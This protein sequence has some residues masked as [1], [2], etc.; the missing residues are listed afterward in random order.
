MGRLVAGAAP[1]CLPLLFAIAA[2]ISNLELD[3]SEQATTIPLQDATFGDVQ[4]GTTSATKTFTIRPATGAQNNQVQSVTENCPDFAVTATNLPATVS[5]VCSGGSNCPVFVTTTY[6]FT[7]VFTPTVAMQVSCVVTV[8]IDGTASTFT[9]SGRG[10]EPTVRIDVS[11]S[12]TLQLGEV[13]VGDTSSAATI[14][15]KNFGSGPQPMTVSA[16]SLDAASQAQGLAITSGTTTSHVVAPNGGNDLYK[17]TCHPTAPGPIAGTLTIASDDPAKPTSTVAITCAGITSNLVFLPSSP[18]L[19][20]GGQA[21]GGT[22]VGEPIDLTITLKNTGTAAMTIHDLTLTGAELSFVTRPAAESSLAINATT[23]VVVRYAATTAVDQGTLGTVVVSHD[24]G[25]TRTINVL[26]ASLAT[27]MSINPAGLVDLGPVCV[28]NTAEKAF[29]VLKNNPGTFLITAI[30]QPAPP[31]QLTGTLPTAGPLAIDNNAITFSASVTPTTPTALSAMFTVTTDIPNAPSQVVNLTALGLAAGVSA[32]PATV[33]LGTVS[34]GTTSTA[35]TITLTNCDPTPLTLQTVE[36]TGANQDDFA[37][38]TAPT[39]LA[40]ESGKAATY[41]VVT[42]P[43][44]GGPLTATLRIQHDRG[45]VEVPL[46]G[47]GTG[48]G[49]DPTPED[50]TYYSCSTGGARGGWPVALMALLVIRRRR[51]SHTQQP[52]GST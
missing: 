40:V 24:N 17:V 50:S 39:N 9:L 52:R 16:V 3:S 29:F 7:A 23:D 43:N 18:A 5:N 2:C 30:D 42:A 41:T 44:N 25:Q 4:V 10:T 31:F 11:P 35:Q 6:D 21:Q 45:I 46:F 47:A 32:T 19:L 13:R 48:R 28:M 33:D 14:L 26:G 51:R 15:V 22:R 36:I 12:T 38:V 37:I 8:M 49:D 1:V 34:V 27:S 20:A